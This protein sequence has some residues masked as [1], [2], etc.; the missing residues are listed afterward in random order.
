MKKKYRNSGST[1]YNINYKNVDKSF[2]KDQTSTFDTYGNS[3]KIITYRTLN[4]RPFR[5]LSKAKGKKK[6]ESANSTKNVADL[7]ELDEN[8]IEAQYE[9]L[10]SSSFNENSLLFKLC[11]KCAPPLLKFISKINK[12][13]ELEV[14][15][16][17]KNDTNKNDS[18]SDMTKKH[19]WKKFGNFFFKYKIFSPLIPHIVGL[20]VSI[21]FKETISAMVL[22]V[23]LV[24]IV[25]YFFNKIKECTRIMEMHRKSRD[26][27]IGFMDYY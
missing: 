11:G 1:R 2:I 20:F 22:A 26:M 9:S 3:I 13:I 21:L 18:N 8:T 25:I 5:V 6:V 15:L 4:V 27:Y 10:K 16:A 12:A 19:K 24:L 14:I 7:L 23:L 17:L